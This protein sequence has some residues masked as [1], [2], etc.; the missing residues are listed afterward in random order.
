L[1]ALSSHQIPLQLAWN[2]VAPFV[3]AAELAA[4]ML[5]HWAFVRVACLRRLLCARCTKTAPSAVAASGAIADP[6]RSALESA[7]ATPPFP[8]GMYVRAFVALFI[9][10]YQ[11]I[12][13]T[14]TSNLAFSSVLHPILGCVIRARR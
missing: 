1:V 11:Q 5:V 8:W 12:S 2:A 7:A 9:Y 14:V 4:V 13:S 10:S 6:T 3:F